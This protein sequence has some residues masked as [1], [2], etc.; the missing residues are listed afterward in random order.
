MADTTSVFYRIGQSVTSAVETKFSELAAQSVNINSI[1]DISDVET[2]AAGHVPTDGQAL[3]WNA[4]HNHWMPGDVTPDYSSG[5][6]VDQFVATPYLSLKSDDMSSGLASIGV[7]ESG[8]PGVGH[9]VNIV[10][11]GG[12]TVSIGNANAAGAECDLTVTRNVT[13]GGNLTVS[14]TTTTVN[15]ANLDVKDQYIK[16]N[17]GGS[18]YFDG[19]LAGNSSAGIEIE[20]GPDA[21][22]A[23]GDVEGPK[24]QFLYNAG[25]TTSAAPLQD[26]GYF[27]TLYI[28]PSAAT[29][30]PVPQNLQVKGLKVQ[31]DA[32]PASASPQFDNLGNYEDFVAGLNA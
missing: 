18:G 24:V 19:S 17:K 15:T 14:G 16:L 12:G 21:A 1:G 29:P 22:S 13:V 25:D 27:E 11:N 26:R 5:I 23:S 3:V 8:T 9:T 32:N 10:A 31:N 30:D 20:V 7:E 28:D 2:T 4:S 6:Q